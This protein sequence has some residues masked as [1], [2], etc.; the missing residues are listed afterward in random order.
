M[1]RVI[2]VIT[3]TKLGVGLVPVHAKDREE[4]EPYL[5]MNITGNIGAPGEIP[6]PI[7]A[8]VE[9]KVQIEGDLLDRFQAG[10]CLRCGADPGPLPAGFA[11]TSDDG[12][13]NV[14]VGPP[15][16]LSDHRSS[17]ASPL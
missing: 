13:A 9:L 8:A 6:L 1:E 2:F 15:L 5:G 7:E 10:L 11:I 17:W 12:R 16:L 3:E 14:I 4:L